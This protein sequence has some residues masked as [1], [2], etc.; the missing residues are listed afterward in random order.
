MKTPKSIKDINS[1]ICSKILSFLFPVD[2]FNVRR[3]KFIITNTDD[4]Y[5]F[6][7][8]RIVRDQSLTIYE[9]LRV[10]NDCYKR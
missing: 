10:C 7:G 2:T 9:T 1:S 5:Y 8:E 4:N 6:A 3:G